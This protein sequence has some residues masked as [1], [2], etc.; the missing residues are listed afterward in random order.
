[1]NSCSPL[2]PGWMW[3]QN[4]AWQPKICLLFKI[5]FKLHDVTS[6]FPLST[7]TGIPRFWM[8]HCQTGLIRSQHRLSPPRQNPAHSSPRSPPRPFWALSIS[9]AKLLIC[10]VTSQCFLHGTE[11]KISTL[12]C[13]V[14]HSA[15]PL[16][17]WYDHYSIR[18]HSGRPQL[19]VIKI[20]RAVIVFI[21]F[22]T[23]HCSLNGDRFNSSVARNPKCLLL[24]NVVW[25]CWWWKTKSMLEGI[26]ELLSNKKPEYSTIFMS[27]KTSLKHKNIIW[28]ISNSNFNMLY[29]NKTWH[30]G[31]SP[32]CYSS[33]LLIA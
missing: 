19:L 11:G 18:P 6:F 10:L 21:W 23:S 12:L 30:W 4:M 27:I 32:H 22:S 28:C 5:P 1:M 29:I 17:H 25:L 24:A 9:C 7:S 8:N 33:D 14:N 3:D 26:L 16:V 20:R 13:A 2:R 15:P 31:G